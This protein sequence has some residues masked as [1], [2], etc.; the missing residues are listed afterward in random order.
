MK[1]SFDDRPGGLFGGRIVRDRA[2]AVHAAAHDA[3]HYVLLPRA[4]VGLEVVED[5]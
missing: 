2:I 4:V 3:S 1:A 5:A